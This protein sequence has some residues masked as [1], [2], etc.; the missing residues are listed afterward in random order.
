MHA[1]FE[2]LRVQQQLRHTGSDVGQPRVDMLWEQLA[3]VRTLQG[4]HHH[5]HITLSRH[6][7]NAIGP[8]PICKG[9]CHN[10][11]QI[12]RSSHSINAIRP[13]PP[14]GGR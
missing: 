14:R 5:H 13:A 12:T 7:I 3:Q 9:V 1:D 8:A 10:H 11:H 2:L 4:R 6:S